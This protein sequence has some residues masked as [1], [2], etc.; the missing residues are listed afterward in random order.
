MAAGPESLEAAAARLE[1]RAPGYLELVRRRAAEL[2]LPRTPEERVRRMIGLV[3]QAAPIDANAPVASP[4]RSVRLAK[5]GVGAL[6][7]FYMLHLAGQV[8]TLGGSTAL[9]GEALCD[10]VAGL[11]QEVAELRAR[12]ARLEQPPTGS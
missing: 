2:G 8:A 11:E 9:M 3:S 6:V 4:R 1:A 10:Y 12:V 5:Q 7:R